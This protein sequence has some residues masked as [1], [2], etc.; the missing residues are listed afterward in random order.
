MY[1]PRRWYFGTV[2]G[3]NVSTPARVRYK[4]AL[5][6]A[7]VGV[8]RSAPLFLSI[9]IGILYNIIRETYKSINL[10]TNQLYFVEH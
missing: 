9:V 10:Q 6:I 4:P 7:Y 8:E 5:V 1:S 2:F 3:I